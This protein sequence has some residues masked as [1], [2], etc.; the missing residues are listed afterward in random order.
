M[1][2][3]FARFVRRALHDAAD[4]IEPSRDVSTVLFRIPGFDGGPGFVIPPGTPWPEETASE[5]AAS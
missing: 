5:E 4:Q 2:G 3:A 1:S